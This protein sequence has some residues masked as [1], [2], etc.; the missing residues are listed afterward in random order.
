M[1]RRTGGRAPVARAVEDTERMLHD[2]EGQKSHYEQ[3]LSR[4]RGQN[5]EIISETVALKAKFRKSLQLLQVY[6]ERLAQAHEPPH[7]D[8]SD[9]APA[10]PPR[11]PLAPTLRGE[12]LRK[13]SGAGA[14]TASDSHTVA[15]QSAATALAPTPAEALTRGTLLSPPADAPADRWASSETPAL[16]SAHERAA[17]AHD[18]ERTSGRAVKDAAPVLA[19]GTTGASGGLPADAGTSQAQQ[20]APVG[21]PPPAPPLASK[22]RAHA[23]HTMI[24]AH[25]RGHAALP[26]AAAGL[27]VT[28][29]AAAHA[30]V[31]A[32]PFAT[33][34]VSPPALGDSAPLKPGAK[35]SASPPGAMAEP[36]RAPR[37]E[38]QRDAARAWAAALPHLPR[39]PPHVAPRA[40]PTHE[41]EPPRSPRQDSASS[42]A[43][44]TDALL[45][46]AA[47]ARAELERHRHAHEEWHRTR[48]MLQDH[49]RGRAGAAAEAGAAER[50]RPARAS[51][52]RRAAPP[53]DPE[54]PQMPP[55]FVP[56]TCTLAHTRRDVVV[57]EPTSSPPAG[58]G[59]AARE[60]GGREQGALSPPQPRPAS[61]RAGPGA[62]TAAFGS[63]VRGGVR[64]DTCAAAAASAPA[65][66]S[67]PA[68]HDAEPRQPAGACQS[69]VPHRPLGRSAAHAG[70][71]S[72][73]GSGGSFGARSQGARAGEHAHTRSSA[74]PRLASAVRAQPRRSPHPRRPTCNAARRAERRRA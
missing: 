37:L 15:T 49:L 3:R 24:E 34:P 5:Q 35:D 42:P 21:A 64:I 6:Q 36:Q 13:S 70:A 18:G 8:V 32:V 45:R 52:E 28:Q 16:R 46:M 50:P 54:L 71:R 26:F 38:V 69:R 63:A 20:H 40:E 51:A 61:E 30:G 59:E 31:G 22:A 68:Q 66:T 72:E 67:E 43:S 25:A 57:I 7:D 4:L 23:A 73:R 65:R 27:S 55:Q 29:P 41:P 11:L 44:H 53:A 58:R 74:R 62:T 2:L 14:A 33:P 9:A 1:P 60:T 39:A 17:A 10:S 48:S 56:R 19:R 47:D 12:A